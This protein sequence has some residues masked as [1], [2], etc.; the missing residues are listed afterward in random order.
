LCN[1]YSKY[2]CIN[3]NGNKCFDHWHASTF[4]EKI[5][6]GGDKKARIERAEGL[7]RERVLIAEGDAVAIKTVA[8]ADKKKIELIAEGEAHAIKFV[9]ESAN[10]YFIDNAKDLKALETTERSLQ[11]NTKI[12]VTEKGISPNLIVDAMGNGEGER[13][14]VPYVRDHRKGKTEKKN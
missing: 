3:Y 10:K 11:Y 14:I 4:T 12:I 7:K 2:E 13:K 1:S 9:N 5:E 6:A 8:D